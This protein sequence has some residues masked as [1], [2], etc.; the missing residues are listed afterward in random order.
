[1]AKTKKIKSYLLLSVAILLMAIVSVFTFSSSQSEK[2]VSKAEFSSYNSISNELPDY[3][4]IEKSTS[5]E[6]VGEVGYVG[7]T[8]YLFQ[9]NAYKNVLIA[10]DVVE[11]GFTAATVYDEN[12][13]Y[14]TTSS[15][16]EVATNVTSEN[17]QSFFV[18]KENYA[19]KPD[20]SNDNIY[21]YFDFQNSLSL[22]YDLTNEDIQNGK[23]GIN[24]MQGRNIQNYTK[25][26]IS[27][28]VPT[29]ASFTPQQ[30]NVQFNL[31]TAA[32]VISWDEN[33]VILNREGCYTLVV[34]LVYH[35][36]EDDGLTFTSTEMLIYYTFMVFNSSTYFNTTTGLPNLTISQNFQESTTNSTVYSRNYFYNY[37]YAKD[38]NTL[39]YL[40]YNPNIYQM[41][42]QYS[43]I[44]EETHICV[45]DYSSTHM[46]ISQ[47]DAYGNE[48]LESNYFVQTYFN[49]TENLVY[50][51][52]NN[53]GVY[54]VSLVYL[55]KTTNAGIETTYSLPLQ[56]L[57][58]SASMVFKNQKQRVY[59]YGYQAVYSDYSNINPLTNQPKEAEL[60]TFDYVNK[61]YENPADITSQ[62][63]NYVLNLA[64]DTYSLKTSLNGI[65]P[66]REGSYNVTKMKEA[67][68]AYIKQDGVAPV[69]SNQ[70]P[71]KF[72]TNATNDANVS[73]IYKVGD[74][75]DKTLTSL[76]N[77]QG[78]NQNEAGTYVYIVQYKYTSYTSN[79]GSL[80][81]SAY[82][83]QVFYFT[84]TNVTPTVTVLDENL[85]GVYTLGYTNKSVYILNDTENNI[86]DA[87]V[88]ILLSAYNYKNK[89]YFFKD[90][91]IKNLRAFSMNYVVFDEI[92]GNDEFNEKVAGK[93]G[94][95][96]DS[97]NVYANAHFTIKIQSANSDRPSVSTFTIDTNDISGI[98]TR[99]VSFASGTNY[100]IGD[101]F[102]NY[103]TNQPII[104]SW[105][106]KDSGA[107]TYGY[108]KFIP[109]E[110]INYYSYQTDENQLSLLLTSLLENDVLPV[111]Y[112][113]NLQ[114]T[115]TWTE[116]NNTKNFENDSTINATY[117][118]STAG[119]YIL[120]I[121]DQAGNSAFYITM[122]DDTAP[123]F[124]KTTF[125]QYE[126]RVIMSSSEVI[127]MPEDIDNTTISVEW[128]SAKAIYLHNLNAYS[129]ITS[130]EYAKDKAV[131]DTKLAEL[132]SQYFTM[133]N[134]SNISYFNNL[135]SYQ[136]DASSISGYNGTYLV[137]PINDTYYIKTPRTT[138]SVGYDRKT[139][140]IHNIQFVDAYGK[141]IE[142]S[143]KILIRD[144]SNTQTYNNPSNLAS[145]YKDFP[146]AYISFFVTSDASK[147]IIKKTETDEPL[148]T[149]NYEF[150]GFLYNKGTN[151][152]PEYTHLKENE[153]GSVTYN[154]TDKKYKFMYYTPVD[155]N[156][157]L[158][159]TFVPLA[160]NGSKVDKITVKYYPFVKTYDQAK[161]Q[162]TGVYY[163]YYTLADTPEKIITV[164]DSQ[165]AGVYAAGDEVTFDIALGNNDF[166]QPGKYVIERIYTEDTVVDNFDYFKRTL[167]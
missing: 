159:L 40:A 51:F 81:A 132:L 113:L 72:L 165:T 54:D 78:F 111:E 134:N 101:S 5:G 28:F 9:T 106:E 32:D 140:H 36:T 79:S 97:S 39:A 76:T 12:L 18:K 103:G 61:K 148:Q 99:N 153:D 120:E 31:N 2:L 8:I 94:V 123:I 112:K 41:Q 142:G 35:Y 55:Y 20:A 77:F 48:M 25:S 57:Q 109:M 152:D 95:Y 167:T 82:H 91:D 86:Y 62:L 130:Y 151:E 131:A 21:Y 66:I 102:S 116:Y 162:D 49:Q 24:L 3:F 156:N 104:F 163:W 43:D 37:A 38:E 75:E 100:V 46:T 122:L 138:S 87:K 84:I 160:E 126:S 69:S 157:E 166:P 83:Y 125:D 146:S 53:L 145:D 47:L 42:I 1:M 22:Y 33:K 150:N 85:N 60:K 4:I 133:E 108:V 6:G 58:Q 80:M 115:S 14:Y 164:F 158:K 149:A 70:T 63:N 23:T 68:N 7:N 44:N 27:G 161:A 118:K 13:T 59:L 127:A 139:S 67:V 50:I 64:E 96:I 92:A 129:N 107:L 11:D 90:E 121:Y 56:D 15:G 137:I 154:V 88:T 52:F 17:Y 155:A 119:I 98:T 124:I 74:D 143:Y 128:S 71:I 73:I 19:Y 26:N 65:N 117:V 34:P 93:S 136:H 135:S 16:A 144:G 141:E 105:N 147:L 30:L 45:I 110:K 89:S 114:N 10:N 29:G